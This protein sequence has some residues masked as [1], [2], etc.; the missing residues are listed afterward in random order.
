MLVSWHLNFQMNLQLLILKRM[1]KILFIFLFVQLSI[2]SNAQPD[3]FNFYVSSS[4][5]EHKAGLALF[6]LDL[7]N[8]TL[9]LQ[10]EFEEVDRSSYLAL[11]E[12]GSFLYT[13]NERKSVLTSFKVNADFSL[14]EIGNRSAESNGPCYVS[15]DPTNQFV[16]TANYSG[17]S[18]CSFQLN[19]SGMADELISQIQHEGASFVDSSRQEAPHPH[20][21]FPI[22]DTKLVLVPDL[23]DDKIC[24]YKL[25]ELGELV[26]L[27]DKKIKSAPAAGPRHVALRPDGKF[28]F[29]MNELNSTIS[30]Y[31][32]NADTG[33]SKE[34]S[35]VSILPDGFKDFSKAADIHITSSGEY[36]YG[37]N[38]G[39]DSIGIC[40]VN[41]E[42]GELSFIG[43]VSCGG[44][45][46]RAFAID[47]TGKYLIVANQHSDNIVVFKI[48][49]ASGNLEL[50]SENSD[51]PS[52]QCIK[53]L[54]RN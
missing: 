46:P 49:Y 10:K 2:M 5:D 45:W 11:D 4:D 23:G 12:T 42:T 26:E 17:G 25:N 29:V 19:E 15:V 3:T 44:E 16:L 51:F 30:S 1:K 36:V 8:G 33:E 13:I 40:K 43:N 27:A 38:R 52:A 34:I 35:T 50:I 9:Q 22:P 24:V 32:F 20:M 6:Q 21:I 54:P 48:D 39:H 47:P 41:K 28:L 53:F 14:T 18:I 7:E 37:S 31:S